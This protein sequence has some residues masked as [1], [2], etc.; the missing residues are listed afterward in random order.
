MKLTMNLARISSFIFY[1]VT[2]STLV[3]CGGGSSSNTDPLNISGIYRL[4]VN[5]T[6][7]GN[8][9]S[10][11]PGSSNTIDYIS[12]IHNLDT[13]ELQLYT[14]D[15]HMFSGSLSNT[16]DITL[17]DSQIPFLDKAYA[18]EDFSYTGSY[19]SNTNTLNL[20]LN[21]TYTAANSSDSPC[22]VK[23]TISANK[24][25]DLTANTNYNNTYVF[26]TVK[27]GLNLPNQSNIR[28]EDQEN[29]VFTNT[30][31]ER[32]QLDAANSGSV[33]V[34]SFDPASGQFIYETKT[35]INEV[36][37]RHTRI[38]G[39]LVNKPGSTDKPSIVYQLYTWDINKTDN[40][41]T[42][43]IYLRAYGKA[44][45]T[46][47]SNKKIIS[48]N[49]ITDTTSTNNIISVIDPTLLGVSDMSQLQL[50]AYE[51][52]ASGAKTGS[53][54]CDSSYADGFKNLTQLPRPDFNQEQFNNT[55]Y[56][57]FS[58]T[59]DP[60]IAD[61]KVLDV[62][63]MDKSNNAIMYNTQ[64]TSKS[65]STD[66]NPGQ[67]IKADTIKVNGISPAPD[68]NSA[69]SI[70]GFIN[71][72][73]PI[74]FTWSVSGAS[75]YSVHYAELTGNITSASADSILST[76]NDIYTQD[77]S[78][79]L[80]QSV[81]GYAIGY[82]IEAQLVASYQ[83]T[84]SAE[85][86]KLSQPVR[87]W[88]GLNGK[89][90]LNFN[91]DPGLPSSPIDLNIVNNVSCDS[92]TTDVTCKPSLYSV[93]YSEN[94]VFLSIVD[95]SSGNSNQYDLELDFTNS[96]TA[97]VYRQ[98]DPTHISIGTASVSAF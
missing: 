17:P 41:L 4:K 64:L 33:V 27:T 46:Q 78:S 58:C 60:S 32:T 35:D 63:I 62:E 7:T 9:S 38:T 74:N 61:N 2:I 30:T 69:Y 84:N 77:S 12:L 88:P 6:S 52:D 37:E 53:P 24:S 97:D 18:L 26:E 5:T 98:N 40:S 83:D 49:Q 57:D 19:D 25:F 86:I 89:L 36:T 16:N 76:T 85:T 75:H 13:N 11:S 59:I 47:T 94:K 23:E 68:K 79:I 21:R 42:Y 90:S 82:A 14:L 45:T 20:T 51:T 71:P 15:G 44:L 95:K 34:N 10:F 72:S 43:Q 1:L 28:G 50:S 80:L 81:F 96:S 91:T 87:I 55:G 73:S 8:C 93:N 22:K 39:L 31:V 65:P 29:M 66:P 48:Y 70:F 67:G 54:V 56:T 3:G 92:I